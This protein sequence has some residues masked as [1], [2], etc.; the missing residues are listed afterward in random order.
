MT[1]SNPDR[2]TIGSW[3]RSLGLG[4]QP[5]ADEEQSVQTLQCSF[6][7]EH[8]CDASLTE[9]L[10]PRLHMLHS[11]LCSSAVQHLIKSRKHFVVLRIRSLIS[12]CSV[13]VW[14]NC[15]EGNVTSVSGQPWFFG[16]LCSSTIVS[17][18]EGHEPLSIACPVALTIDLSLVSFPWLCRIE[19]Q[20]LSVAV[21]MPMEMQVPSVAI[22]TIE[23]EYMTPPMVL[24]INLGLPSSSV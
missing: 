19:W 1:T 11:M 6:S 24:C 8:T 13:A 7:E 23:F 3:A 22:R 12:T 10:L 16:V 9:Q 21:S 4:S 17:D 18:D 15:T 20:M 14:Q 2:E 5:Y